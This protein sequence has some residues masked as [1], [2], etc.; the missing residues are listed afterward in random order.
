MKPTGALVQGF[1]AESALQRAGAGLAGDQVAG[2]LPAIALFQDATGRWTSHVL[3]R[4][5]SVGRLADGSVE[6][7][8]PAVLRLPGAG[9]QRVLVWT[10]S[11]A[12]GLPR[13]L[14]L[15]SPELE[16]GAGRQRIRVTPPGGEREARE[17]AVRVVRGAVHAAERA[18]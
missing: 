12:R 3:G 15:G 1:R 11:G 9:V 7:E 5:R 13:G 8:W 16:R 6:F 14:L 17:L 18:R 10:G 2:A 4:L